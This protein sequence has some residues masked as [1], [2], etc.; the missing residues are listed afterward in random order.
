[1]SGTEIPYRR[2]VT[3]ADDPPL[4]D[5]KL[6]HIATCSSSPAT[7]IPLRGHVPPDD[8]GSGSGKDGEVWTKTARKDEN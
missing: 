8:G 4:H 6:Y 2:G 7:G 1:M 3:T 5:P